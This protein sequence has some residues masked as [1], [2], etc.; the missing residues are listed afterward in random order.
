MY[1]RL[2]ILRKKRRRARNNAFFSSVRGGNQTLAQGTAFP[3]AC[4]V[5]SAGNYSCSQRKGYVFRRGSTAKRRGQKFA[6]MYLFAV[7][8][9]SSWQVRK[10]IHK[11]RLAIHTTRNTHERRHYLYRHKEYIYVVMYICMS[12]FSQE[13][14]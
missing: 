9:L 6:T 7:T 5:N 11:D 10:S 13:Y 8:A 3:C 2:V 4:I 14:I 12:T 1:I